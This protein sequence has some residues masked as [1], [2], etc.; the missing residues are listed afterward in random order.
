[1]RKINDNPGIIPLNLGTAKVQ[2]FT[3]TLIHYYDLNPIILEINKLYIKSKNISETIIPNSEYLFETS[4]YFKI[5]KLIQDRVETKIVEI[6]PHPNRIKRGLINALGSVFKAVS[7]NLDASDGERYEKLIAELQNNQNNLAGNILKENSISLSI[8]KKFNTTIQ[9]I[10]HNEKL[11]ES[12][13]NQVS[14]I[15]QKTTYRENANLIKDTLNQIINVYEIIDATLQDIENS[16]AFSRLETMHPS[17]IKTEDLYFELLKIQKKV[18][19]Q[20]MP[21][22]VTLE[23]ILIFEKFIKLECFIL[24][25]KIT[26]LLHFPI[27]YP[28]LFNYLHLYSIPV[29][30][31]GQFKVIV[32][33]NKFLLKNKLHYAY[34]GQECQEVNKQSFICDNMDLQEINENSPCT[35]KLLDASKATSTCQ[36]I[37]TK[38]TQPI[39]KQLETADQWIFILPKEEVVK[40][41]CRHQEESQKLFGTY[42][43]QIPNNCIVTVNHQPIINNQEEVS[44]CSLPILFPDIDSKVDM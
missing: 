39:I 26:Y 29:L 9:Q 27:T 4:N 34:R 22:K 17:I 36:Q 43:M 33:R 21:L 19:L 40:L 24:N 32:P 42:L 2:E 13:L 18:G 7:G 28:E 5:L 38:V 41:K 30:R 25:N 15:V 10:S 44:S 3:Y 1:M 6:L 31:K 23:N 11:L 8:I 12:K 20:Q 35:V 16:I 14:F 37:E